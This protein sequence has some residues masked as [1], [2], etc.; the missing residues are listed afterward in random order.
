VLAPLAY[1]PALSTRERRKGDAHS[2]LFKGKK[3]G[4]ATRN[5]LDGLH[6]RDAKGGKKK[7]EAPL[8]GAKYI[9]R[10]KNGEPLAFFLFCCCCWRCIK[11]KS[12]SCCKKKR[13]VNDGEK[14]KER[15]K[16]AFHL[17]LYDDDNRERKRKQIIR[18]CTPQHS[19]AYPSQPR[20]PF[21]FF[22]SIS[23]SPSV[24]QWGQVTQIAPARYLPS[25]LNAP[26]VD[27]P[28]AVTL[29]VSPR[30]PYS[31]C[32]SSTLNF[33]CSRSA[34]D[35]SVHDLSVGEGGKMGCATHTAPP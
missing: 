16:G 27:L 30:S 20:L 14:K 11:G 22:P 7:N 35:G 5:R 34:G 4:K 32:P 2:F 28:S 29:S 12:L 8:C 24:F 31:P 21:P 23:L 10:E 3:T 15:K 18:D 25:R 33:K 6:S 26:N 19:F 9:W 17:E 1:G 13:R